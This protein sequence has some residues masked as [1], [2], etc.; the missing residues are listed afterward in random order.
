M[1]NVRMQFFLLHIDW[2]YAGSVTK[3]VLAVCSIFNPL[4]NNCQR[5]VSSRV[6]SLRINLSL[7]FSIHPFFSFASVPAVSSFEAKLSAISLP[8][9]PTCPGQQSLI[10]SCRFEIATYAD[11]HV[12]NNYAAPFIEYIYYESETIRDLVTGAAFSQK[13]GDKNKHRTLYRL[14]LI[15]GT[16]YQHEIF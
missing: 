16:L 9:K 12:T 11:T 2:S 4:S 15:L 6:V 10:C 13:R 8:I 3:A 1:L 14:L 5:A 7:L